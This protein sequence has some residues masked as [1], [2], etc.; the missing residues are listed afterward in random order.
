MTAIV[1]IFGSPI[2]EK[3]KRKKKEEEKKETL[4]KILTLNFEFERALFVGK[5][6]VNE[7]LSRML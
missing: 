7:D 6:L 3:R 1:E 4:D 2:A 5:G